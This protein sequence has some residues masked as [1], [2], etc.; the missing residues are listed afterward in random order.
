MLLFVTNKFSHIRVLFSCLFGILR[1]SLKRSLIIRLADEMHITDNTA[2]LYGTV[3][4]PLPS[5]PCTPHPDP[6]RT[7]Y[8]KRYV[9]MCVR[10]W[11][12][13]LL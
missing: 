13:T 10:P 2:V 9:R 1:Y 5:M 4:T 12:V 3:G 8:M 11:V 7:K 6:F